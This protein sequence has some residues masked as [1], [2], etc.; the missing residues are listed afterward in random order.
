MPSGGRIASPKQGREMRKIAEQSS[1]QRRCRMLRRKSSFSCGARHISAA[2]KLLLWVS[3]LTRGKISCQFPTLLSWV[4]P[5]PPQP[6]EERESF[7][8]QQELCSKA[9]HAARGHVQNSRLHHHIFHPHLARVRPERVRYHC[10]TFSQRVFAFFLCFD[11]S[12]SMAVLGNLC[13]D[14]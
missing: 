1:R 3:V 6:R 11:F 8:R 9:L 12:F 10:R 13:K 14:S 7:H 2:C 4:L 5:M